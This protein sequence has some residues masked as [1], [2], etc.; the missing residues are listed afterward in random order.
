MQRASHA[1]Q[2]G[3]AALFDMRGKPYKPMFP[4][5]GRFHL[6]IIVRL[7]GHGGIAEVYEVMYQGRR[8]ALKVLQ[9]RLQ[10]DPAHLKRFE[11]EGRFLLRV[12]HPN[13]VDVQDMGVHEGVFWIRMELLDGMDLREAIHRLGAMS[14]GLV[15]SWMCQAAYGAHQCHEVGVVHRDIKPENIMLL[16]PDGVKLL[17]LGLAKIQG[18]SIT[19]EGG[20][21][22]GVRGTALYMAPEQVRNENTTSAVDVYALGMTTWEMLVGA[23]PFLRGGQRFEMLPTLYKQVHEEVQPLH[24]LGFDRRLSRVM[25]SALAKDW[26]KRQPN[27]LAFAEE[28]GDAV[29]A[30]LAEHPDDEPRPGEPV[31]AWLFGERAGIPSFGTGPMSGRSGAGP[32]RSSVPMPIGWPTD[33]DGAPPDLE[34]IPRFHTDPL[35][36]VPPGW[37]TPRPTETETAAEVDPSERVTDLAPMP[38]AIRHFDTLSLP[39]ELRDPSS[40]RALAGYRPAGK[41]RRAAARAEPVI[42]LTRS[43]GIITFTR[44]ENKPTATKTAPMATKTA[45]MATRPAGPAPPRSNA[46]SPRAARRPAASRGRIVRQIALLVVLVMVWGTAWWTMFHYFAP[47]RAAPASPRRPARAA[48]PG[49]L[50]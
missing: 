10:L 11:S 21:E 13:L 30:Y 17:D 4:P 48:P 44:Q 6:F 46:L 7:L 16:R 33:V 18:E 31:L 15:G 20:V 22:E 5:G 12:R 1:A 27:G 37:L 40:I 43:R 36:H 2:P 47:A 41:T 49:A 38:L 34:E 35:I 28:L 25:E 23:H 50:P 19:V 29:D 42:E 32:R 26:R 24:Q 3:R 8:Y 45:P 39:P 9:R 14:V